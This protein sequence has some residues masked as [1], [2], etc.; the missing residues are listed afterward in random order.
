MPRKISRPKT[1]AG[2]SAVTVKLSIES[3]RS[4][5]DMIEAF[6]VRY[7]QGLFPNMS[8]LLQIVIDK[9]VAEIGDNPALLKLEAEDFQSRY[10]HRRPLSRAVKE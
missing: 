3:Q 4:L 8:H 9:Y 2:C 6:Q 10:A 1:V 5:R 7:P